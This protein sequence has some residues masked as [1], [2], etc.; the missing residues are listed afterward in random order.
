MFCEFLVQLDKTNVTME[1]LESC[2]ERFGVP[3]KARIIIDRGSNYVHIRFKFN[4]D[5]L[6]EPSAP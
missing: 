1:E 4:S 2:K 3:A 5:D 6:G